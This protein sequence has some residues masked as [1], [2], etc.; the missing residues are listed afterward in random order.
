MALLLLGKIKAVE[1][2]M[3][4][5][6]QNLPNLEIRIWPHVGNSSEID[7]ILAGFDLPSTLPP[8]PN[9]KLV[10]SIGAGVDHILKNPTWIGNAAVVR[11]VSDSLT[12]QMVEYVTLAVLTF[13]RRLMDYLVLKNTQQWQ[14]LPTA[15]AGSFTIGILGLGVLGSAVATQ[16][17]RL[18]FPVRGWSRTPKTLAGIEG[19]AGNDQFHAFLRE[20]RVLICLLPLTPETE[21]ILNLI[22]FSALP[23]GAFL[24]NVARGSHLVE[25][26]LLT[27][28]NS[29]QIAAAWLDVFQTE[30]LPKDHPFW[31][32]ERIIITPHI[33]AVT[34][35]S[36]VIPQ[37]I[38]AIDCYQTGKPLNNRVDLYRGY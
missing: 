12:A 6:Q 5:L 32:D 37:V 26:D 1:T 16:L 10:I 34:L 31:L 3:S 24:I 21:G 29:G 20:C 35:P 30:P 28:L 14:Y 27:A 2:W 17:K 36:E 18:G 9:L 15:D 22:T 7:M 13:E 8:F 38:N 11:V 33:A 4:L 25:A 19:F 23:Q